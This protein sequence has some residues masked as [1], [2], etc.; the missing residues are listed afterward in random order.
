MKIRYLLAAA[1]L[2]LSL[3]AAT[4]NVVHAQLSRFPGSKV[5]DSGPNPVGLGKDVAT[6]FTY[7]IH[8][9]AGFDAASDVFDVVPAE[10]DVAGVTPSCGLASFEEKNKPGDKLRP[11]VITWNLD[12]CDSASS[13]TL[14]VSIQTDLNPGHGKRGIPFFEPTSCGPLYL[15]DRALLFNATSSAVTE[16]SNGLFVAT[17]PVEGDPGCVDA[18]GDGWT[19]ACGDTVDTDSTVYPN[20]PEICGDGKDNNLDGQVDEGCIV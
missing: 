3:S 4:A 14:T 6:N 17:C 7:T 11:D 10:F 19:V 12:G 15:N 16:R 18:D 5:L 9:N 20:A 2:L 1:I 8:L 13:Q